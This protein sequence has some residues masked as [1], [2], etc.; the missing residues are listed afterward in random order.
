MARDQSKAREGG[1]RRASSQAG[2]AIDGDRA[3]RRSTLAWGTPDNEQGMRTRF[4][5]GLDNGQAFPLLDDGVLATAGNWIDHA[6]LAADYDERVTAALSAERYRFR[7]PMS[8]ETDDALEHPR[9][10]LT[11]EWLS[12]VIGD[13][14]DDLFDMVKRLAVDR[15]VYRLQLDDLLEA[16]QGFHD[17]I[18]AMGK[19]VI[20]LQ[21]A[22]REQEEQST[23]DKAHIDTLVLQTH[24]H[25]ATENDLRRR[26]DDAQR[27]IRED[28]PSAQSAAAGQPSGHFHRSAK[29]PDPAKY[30]GTDATQHVEVWV[31]QVSRKLKGNADHFYNE[32]GRLNHVVSL[33][34]GR[35]QEMVEPLLVEGHPNSLNTAEEVLEW[36]EINFKNTNRVAEARS[37]FRGLRLQ[38]DFQVFRSRFVEL[39]TTARVHADD[40]KYEF[41]QRL[42]AELRKHLMNLMDDDAVDFA[43]FANAA[44]R[45]AQHLEEIRRNGQTTTTNEQRPTS[46]SN[47]NNRRRGNTP[48][49]NH[50]VSSSSAARQASP[51][52]PSLSQKDREEKDKLLREGKCFICHNTGHMANSCPRK[53]LV[54]HSLVPSQPKEAPNPPSANKKEK[55][56]IQPTSSEN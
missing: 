18:T 39:A 14:P 51:A 12:K 13:R 1:N 27:G 33:L 48:S 3:A 6:A 38:G 16:V 10:P 8:D 19:R 7:P 46:G 47:F 15:D 52:T 20:E 29:L 37:S 44:A 41:E 23:R 24:Q 54:V 55:D 5:Q 11:E 42:T 22:I 53:N 50:A 56:E 36:L 9:V 30:S 43:T 32:E 2:T 45:R 21:D 49:S 40:W 25:L 17:T 35:A 28:T 26:L 34:E 31:R 4:Q